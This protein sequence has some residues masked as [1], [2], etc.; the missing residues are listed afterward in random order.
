MAH[1]EFNFKITDNVRVH[2]DFAPKTAVILCKTHDGNAIGRSLTE[3]ER[4]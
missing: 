1:P 4:P 3:D 2:V